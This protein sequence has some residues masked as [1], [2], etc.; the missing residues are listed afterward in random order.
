MATYDVF[1][2]RNMAPKG[3][4]GGGRG[5]GASRALDNIWVD[6]VTL[7]IDKITDRLGKSF[8]AADILEFS[9]VRRDQVLLQGGVYLHTPS[10]ATTTLDFGH[11]GDRDAFYDSY[12][13]LTGASD[14]I[15]VASNQTPVL[16]A[17]PSSG[18]RKITMEF[19][20]GTGGGAV[21]TVW[22]VWLDVNVDDQFYGV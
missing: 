19:E 18:T 11:S 15:M 14:L 12:A 21:F 17:K 3:V 13:I 22:W 16:V 4:R 20:S 2:L 7:D 10:T 1:A 8:A 9:E 6:K 5:R